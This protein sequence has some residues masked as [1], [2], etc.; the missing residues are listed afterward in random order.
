MIQ[1]ET[2][3]QV[4]EAARR[5]IVKVVGGY[6]QLTPKGDVHLGC[7][8]FHREKTPSPSLFVNAAKGFYYCHVCHSAGGAVGF[9]MQTEKLSHDDA[10][11]FLGKKLGISVPDEELAPVQSQADGDHDS[12]YAT[13]EYATRHYEANLRMSEE[14]EAYG[15]TYFRHRGF[16]DETISTFRLGY[17]LNTSNGLTNKAMA[18]G[19]AMDDLLKNGLTKIS[20]SNG[21]RFDYFRGRVMFPIQNTAGKVIAFG[22]RVLDARTKGVN[23]KYLNSPET[24]LYKKTDIVYGIYQARDEIK[25]KDKCYLVEGYTDVISMHQSGIANVVASS[26]TALTPNQIRLIKHF[27][28]NI[29]VLYDGDKAGIHASLRGI[30]LILHEGM[31]VR[32]LLLPDDDD[33]D[34]FSRKHTAE[35]FQTY[36]EAHETDFINFE[37]ETLM[38]DCAGDPLKR[39]EATH[40]IVTSIAEVRERDKR[41]A[42]LKEVSRLMGVS[43]KIL[44]G[45]L[46]KQMEKNAIEQR[47]KDLREE[48]LS[49]YQARRDAE[50]QAMQQQPLPL[51]ADI[52]PDLSPGEIDALYAS[53]MMGGSAPKPADKLPTVAQGPKPPTEIEMREILRYLVTYTQAPL[54]VQDGE[55]TITMT[56]GDYIVSM[57][58]AD[59]LEPQDPTLR[60]I[61]DEYRSAPD[62]TAICDTYYLGMSD[63]GVESFVA[64]ALGSRPNLSKLLSKYSPVEH[65]KD[66]LD[67]FVPRAIQE[68]QIKQVM[69]MIDDTTEE[70]NRLI[71]QGAADEAIDQV[72]KTLNDLNQVKREL[73]LAM[74]ERFI[75]RLS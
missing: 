72:M 8:P 49:N 12:L 63:P 33:P 7:C 4:A 46:E 50:A 10:I 71:A 59:G 5:E 61:F 25:K 13:M 15:L 31:N 65:E 42:Y 35:E 40:T 74:G 18:D 66:Q 67:D 30:D 75:V 14:G 32:V 36:V 24:E 60:K 58:E 9:V 21:E 52:P 54:H 68:L 39:A 2:I 41:E 29:T 53:G 47:E 64:N 26:G 37:L 3:S 27:T 70:M 43:E 73:S 55:Q 69:K 62:R 28:N 22:A 1:N 34:S 57:L 48:R 23:V 51:P 16:T 45:E 6:V 20:E 56:V 11:R 44:H 19:Y 38:A 17:S